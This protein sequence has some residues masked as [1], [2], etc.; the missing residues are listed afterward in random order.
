MA[1]IGVFIYKMVG[2]ALLLS[3]NYYEGKL[4]SNFI[5]I[6]AISLHSIPTRSYRG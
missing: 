2:L 6:K 1:R 5:N 4:R 3:A